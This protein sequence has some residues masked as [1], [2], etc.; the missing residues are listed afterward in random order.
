[1]TTMWKGEVLFAP[2]ML[3]FLTAAV[4]LCRDHGGDQGLHGHA[5]AVMPSMEMELHAQQLHATPDNGFGH[6]GKI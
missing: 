4:L 3:L 1:M 5:M 2:C 6:G